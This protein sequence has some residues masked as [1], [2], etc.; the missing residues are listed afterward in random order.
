MVN[1]GRAGIAFLLLCGLVWGGLDKT[2][3]SRATVALEE[4]HPAVREL[5]DSGGE[6]HV[7]PAIMPAPGT[8]SQP[9]H[10]GHGTPDRA[11]G[12]GA[13]GAAAQG[14]S[15]AA[16]CKRVTADCCDC[17]T[18]KIMRTRDPAMLNA[19]PHLC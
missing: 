4:A 10:S 19:G 18:G 13:R 17:K 15:C 9:S 14:E 11:L 12:E 3:L 5:V 16:G 6:R 8:A 1:C 7:H 2:E